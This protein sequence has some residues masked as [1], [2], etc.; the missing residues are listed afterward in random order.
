MNQY[1]ITYWEDGKQYTVVIGT[2]DEK[3]LRE[4]FKNRYNR[5]TM[6]AI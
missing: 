5:F 3:S 6:E 1:R 4:S 2:T